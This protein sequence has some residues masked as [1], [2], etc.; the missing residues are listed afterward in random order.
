MSEIKGQLLGVILVLS[1]FALISLSMKTV[2]GEYT[3][4]IE[5]TATATITEVQGE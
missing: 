4:A 1:L 5:E 2:V 3:N